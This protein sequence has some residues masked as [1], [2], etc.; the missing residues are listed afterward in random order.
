MS[1]RWFVSAAAAVFT[2]WGFACAPAIAQLDDYSNADRFNA[3]LEPLRL[4]QV[5]GEGP[6]VEPPLP[7]V[8][9]VDA[10]VAPDVDG[11]GAGG[12]AVPPL[13]ALAMGGAASTGSFISLA[14]VPNMIGDFLLPTGEI[15]IDTGDQGLVAGIGLTSCRFK[16][17]E[18]SSPL[19]THRIF[20]QY[21]HFSNAAFAGEGGFGPSAFESFDIDRWIAGVEYPFFNDLFS[22]EIRAAWQNPYE[23]AGSSSTIS[24]QDFIG[25]MPTLKALLWQTET[26]AIAAGMGINIPFGDAGDLSSDGASATVKKGSVFLQPYVAWVELWTPNTFTHLVTAIDIPLGGNAV[27]YDGDDTGGR[28]TEQTFLYLDIALGHFF[29]QNPQSGLITTIAGVVEFHY[30]T[31][32]SDAD[33]FT[34]AIGGGEFVG[35]GGDRK[36]IDVADITVGIHTE[37]ATDTRFVVAAVFPLQNQALRPHDGELQVILE[38]RF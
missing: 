11:P 37:F 28:I 4:A 5:P 27:Y 15:S 25:L 26:T 35:F 19:P 9:D 17:S 24:G 29:Y 6:L 12:A 7:I 13:G 16:V 8:P 31:S 32:L 22:I 2:A 36:S 38:Q 3:P 14:R 23:F 20:I 21:Q 18:N 30:A 33:E 10:P 1:S 34:I